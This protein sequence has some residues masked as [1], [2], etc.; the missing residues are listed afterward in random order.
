LATVLAI[1]LAIVPKIGHFL[2]F[3][4]FLLGHSL[5]KQL[6]TWFVV[7]FKNIRSFFGLSV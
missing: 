6:K 1:V 2:T 7:F 3:G 5:N 4:Y